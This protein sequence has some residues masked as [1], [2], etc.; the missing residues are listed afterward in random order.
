MSFHLYAEGLRLKMV[1]LALK[2]ADFIED[3]YYPKCYFVRYR[4][5]IYGTITLTI[6]ECS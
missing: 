5:V 4:I 6:G 1:S 2:E 3:K